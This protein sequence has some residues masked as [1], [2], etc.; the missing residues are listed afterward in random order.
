MHRNKNFD[1]RKW[2]TSLQVRLLYIFNF[3]SLFLFPLFFSF[4]CSDWPC[5]QLKDF[6]ERV[7][8]M[9][10]FYHG[11]TTCNTP[12]ANMVDHSAIARDE[13]HESEAS[14][15]SVFCFD[16]ASSEKSCFVDGL[17]CFISLC[18]RGFEFLNATRRE[19]NLPQERKSF[20]QFHR[21][22]L[23]GRQTK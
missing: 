19:W 16:N 2:H 3:F 9:S 1:T 13:L 17:V 23:R 11:E 15:A 21:S 22:P 18:L 12:H 10:K 14:E 7:I 4:C 20:F 5:L 8:E 6:K